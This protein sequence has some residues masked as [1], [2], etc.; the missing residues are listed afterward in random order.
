MEADQPSSSVI[1]QARDY[2]AP[3][4][5]EAAERGDVGRELSRRDH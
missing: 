2:K 5:R 4:G 3:G 1:I